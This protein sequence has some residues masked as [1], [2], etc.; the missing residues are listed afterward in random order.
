[1]EIGLFVTCLNDSLDPSTG[2]AVVNV[3][4]RLGHRVVFPS[5]Q[6]CCGQMHLNSGYRS[7]ATE[8]ARNFVRTF[9][10]IDVI[11][12]PS[13]SCVTTVRDLYGY[14][15]TTVNDGAL[16]EDVTQLSNRIFEFSQLLVDV[17]GVLDVG[18]RFPRR[19]AYHPTCHSLRGLQLGDGPVR[20]L[21]AVEGLEL[22]PLGRSENCCGFGGTFSIKNPDASSS[23]LEDKLRWI[24][25][26]AAQVVTATD[27]SC[28]M[29]IGG[30]S[31]RSGPG[32]E[33][34]HLAEILASTSSRGPR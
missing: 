10:D 15:A 30:G 31:S 32:I 26:S 23:I 18:A 34:K 24:R 5:A 12:S 9:R 25:T 8:L 27:N 14:L 2:Q 13:A 33:T 6:T 19:V 28:L 4:E 11:V 1:M 21:Q 3:L 20:L 17:L 22:M 29:H 7:H 16:L